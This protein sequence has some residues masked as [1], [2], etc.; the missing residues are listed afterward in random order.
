MTALGLLGESSRLRRVVGLVAEVLDE[1]PDCLGQLSA[2]QYKR[3]LERR[4]SEIDVLGLAPPPVELLA[5]AQET[6]QL[7]PQLPGAVAGVVPQST[8]DAAGP[9]S[10]SQQM[11]DRAP[12]GLS[13]RGWSR[14]LSGPSWMKEPTPADCEFAALEHSYVVGG[15]SLVVMRCKQRMGEVLLLF[16]R[17]GIECLTA[18]TLRL[19]ADAG[20]GAPGHPVE[21]TEALARRFLALFEEARSFEL[22]ACTGLPFGTVLADLSRYESGELFPVA[23]QRLR[24]STAMPRLTLEAMGEVRLLTSETARQ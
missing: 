20:G 21:V 7:D 18:E 4:L 10:G 3:A 5:P 12:C 17:I 16:E 15:D 22:D 9:N 23:L 6:A 2:L 13:S 14:S 1:R 11:R 8:P 19:F 24:D